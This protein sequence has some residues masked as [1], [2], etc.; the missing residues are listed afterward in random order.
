LWG[1]GGAVFLVGI[2]DSVLDT[3]DLI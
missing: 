1:G 3:F 2:R